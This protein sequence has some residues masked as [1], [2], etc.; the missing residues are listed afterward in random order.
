MS[1]I[2]DGIEHI[3]GQTYD[4]HW[5]AALQP[6]PMLEEGDR[7]ASTE[8]C[9]ARQWDDLQRACPEGMGIVFDEHDEGSGYD[10]W[11]VEA[12]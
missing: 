11:M 5:Q 6:R 10:I 8:S 9:D 12:M 1:I 7:I 3:N 4:G 2:I